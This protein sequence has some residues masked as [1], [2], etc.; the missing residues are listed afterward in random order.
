VVVVE[1]LSLSAQSVD[2]GE[3]LADYFR[4]A[5]IAHYLIVRTRRREV[6]HHRRVAEGFETRVV[7]L[8]VILLDPPGIGLDP[9]SVY[10]DE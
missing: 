4:V 8:G 1:V 10:E 3:K 7:S 5:S 6:I 2:V 9:A